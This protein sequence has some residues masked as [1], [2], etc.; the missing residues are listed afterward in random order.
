[1]LFVTTL[2]LTHVF[3]RR[4]PQPLHS[5]AQLLEGLSPFMQAFMHSAGREQPLTQHLASLWVPMQK[6]E[7]IIK[8]WQL[9]TQT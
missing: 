9:G 8:T 6:A 7:G 4:F 3:V 1:M 5:P 2:K